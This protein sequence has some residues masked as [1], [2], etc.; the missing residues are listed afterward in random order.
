M[1]IEPTEG[2]SLDNALGDALAKSMGLETAAPAPEL[3]PELPEGDTYV[4]A[5]GNPVNRDG[6]PVEAKRAEGD[7]NYDDVPLS[8]KER[9][10]YFG[11]DPSLFYDTEFAFSDGSD[12]MTASQMNDWI[13]ERKKDEGGLVDLR[14]QQ[15]QF[16]Q[17]QDMAQAQAGVN[18]K[19]GQPLSKANY[20]RSELI[21]QRDGADWRALQDQ[22]GDKAQIKRLQLDQQINEVENDIRIMNGEYQQ[23]L[24]GFQQ[25]IQ[26][27]EIQS[28]AKMH[29]EW[30]T[31]EQGMD[32]L[33]KIHAGLQGVMNISFDQM[34]H[35][36]VMTPNGAARL[37]L[38][39]QASKY[40]A[41]GNMDEN[42]VRKAATSIK[43]G[44]TI[45]AE[46]QIKM[47]NARAVK[48]AI[49]GTRQQ[50]NAAAAALIKQAGGI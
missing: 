9:A 6:T 25:N 15:Q 17:Q 11:V 50:K 32:G 24:G 49:G 28:I 30:E 39:E 22:Y 45:S 7:V 5:D 42:K 2:E 47:Q 34:I 4:D 14:Q 46:A 3:A 8:A 44:R 23:A 33:R 21:S 43:A 13:Q 18:Q 36:L 19:Y 40:G 12:P 48:A 38:F 31:Q 16:Q 26:N 1:S 37:P 35:E 10:E 27:V 41:I 29:P 20:I